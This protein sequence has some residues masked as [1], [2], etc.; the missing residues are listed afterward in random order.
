MHTL[1]TAYALQRRHM[2]M[3][4]LALALVMGSAAAAFTVVIGMLAALGPAKHGAAHPA[5]RALRAE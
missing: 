1:E 2:V 4:A 3:A 5:D